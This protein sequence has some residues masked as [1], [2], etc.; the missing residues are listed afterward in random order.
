MAISPT[1]SVMG[2][3]GL[4]SIM[5]EATSGA[6][7]AD[8]DTPARRRKKVV[9]LKWVLVSRDGLD[10]IRHVTVGLPE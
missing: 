5:M 7:A 10:C 3:Q 4:R 2:A 8:S 9:A 6:M 1:D